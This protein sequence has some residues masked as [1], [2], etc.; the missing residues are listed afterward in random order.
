MKLRN[1]VIL[2]FPGLMAH[3]SCFAQRIL[4]E[5]RIHYSVTVIPDKGKE[6]FSAGFQNAGKTVWLRANMARVDFVSPIRQQTIIYSSSSGKAIML[7]ESG[8]EKYQWNLDSLQWR[9]INRKWTLDSLIETGD[10]TEISGQSCKKVLGILPEKDTVTIFYAPN[11]M[12]LA[13]GYEPMFEKLKGLVV[14]YEW[15][16]EGLRIIYTLETL[17]TAPVGASRFDIPKTGYKIMEASGKKPP[18]IVID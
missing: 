18:N 7:R 3:F 12:P 10:E 17:Q 16:T 4:S 14:Q 15:K 5:A 2:I 8:T 13:R 9:Q 11:L 6:N 1:F